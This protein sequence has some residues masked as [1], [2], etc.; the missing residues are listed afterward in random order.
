M[1]KLLLK[2]TVII[3]TLCLLL[4]STLCYAAEKQ[5]AIVI[6]DFGEDVK[7]AQ[8][9]LKGDIP[10]TVAIMPF[11]GKSTEQANV[12]HENGL[13]VII[14]LP[15]EPKKGKKSWLGPDG[16][17]TDL[18]DEEINKRLDRALTL[19]PHAKGLNNHMG[20]KVMEDRRIVT[21]IVQFAKKHDLYLIDSGTTPHSVMPEIASAYDIPCFPRSVFLD[22]TLSTYQ[23]VEKQLN[24]F[25]KEAPL[26][27]HPIAIGHVGIKGDQTYAAIKDSLPMFEKQD[28]KL[29]FPSEW[30]YPKIEIDL[31]SLTKGEQ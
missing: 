11:L 28:L 12:A 29:V 13:E 2:Q 16:I 14:H 20:S 10:V 3:L 30:A 23:H 8:S 4:P 17:T 31:N 27:D 5:I 7:G 22:D 24:H 15:L 25:V 1:V 9:F 18:S 21:L 19:V 6:D 26:Y